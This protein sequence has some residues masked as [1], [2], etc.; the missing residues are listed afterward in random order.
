MVERNFTCVEDLSVGTILCDLHD[1]LR[2]PF[3]VTA[4]SLWVENDHALEAVK[5]LLG[6]DT[7]AAR[8]Y[9]NKH[10]VVAG[11]SYASLSAL[12]VASYDGR[13]FVTVH[14]RNKEPVKCH[15]KTTN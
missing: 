12:A 15:E 4:K 5:A 11:F 14:L 10:L 13:Y 2:V 8:H 7:E 1:G 9:V 3:G 6:P